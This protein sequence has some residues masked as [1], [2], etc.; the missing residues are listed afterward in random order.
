MLKSPNSV[1]HTST[2]Q[3][4]PELIYEQCKQ[5]YEKVSASLAI[6]VLKRENYNIAKLELI[7]ENSS[8][9]ILQSFNRIAQHN[10]SRKFQKTSIKIDEIT[11][12]EKQINEKLTCLDNL[13]KCYRS[14]Q[15]SS[16][17]QEI[18][19]LIVDEENAIKNLIKGSFLL[20][21]GQKTVINEYNSI[22]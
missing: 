8:D 22:I 1:T 9:E 20:E 17:G 4:D 12:L 13:I 18:K 10:L 15:N 11:E 6:L 5:Y 14:I 16:A 3:F 7:N 21:E 19:K 2:S